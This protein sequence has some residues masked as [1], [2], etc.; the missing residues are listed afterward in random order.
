MIRRCPREQPDK[1]L[2][3]LRRVAGILQSRPNA[4]VEHFHLRVHQF[5]FQGSIVKK[6]GVKTIACFQI[7]LCLDILCLR[8]QVRLYSGGNQFRHTK[9]PDRMNA[10]L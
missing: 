5:C 8:S 2:I 4:L 9:G 3:R 7:A 6:T 10:V 1:L